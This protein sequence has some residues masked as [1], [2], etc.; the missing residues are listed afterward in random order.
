[1]LKISLIFASIVLA[2]TIWATTNVCNLNAS[3]ELKKN[4]L[5]DLEKDVGH[6]L[7]N[8][9]ISYY[10][11]LNCSEK[12]FNLDLQQM[13]DNFNAISQILYQYITTDIKGNK[14]K[15]KNNEL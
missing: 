4:Q 3:L 15:L 1:M 9:E 2:I 6:E 14:I 11:K 12:E 8:I 10:E 7:G 13:I 5:E